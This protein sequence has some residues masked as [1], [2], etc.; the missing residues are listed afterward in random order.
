MISTNSNKKKI[1]LIIGR[2]Q[3]LTSEHLDQLLMP[4]LERCDLVIL[5][6]G[7]SNTNENI[8]SNNTLSRNEKKEWHSKNPFPFELRKRMVRD[9]IA[10]TIY[11][12]YNE[13]LIILPMPDATISHKPPSNKRVNRLL[14]EYKITPANIDSYNPANIWYYYLGKILEKYVNSNENIEIILYGSN[15]DPATEAYLLKIVKLSLKGLPFKTSF[16]EAVKNGES[17]VNATKVRAALF[18]ANRN[19]KDINYL[20]EYVPRPVLG[21]LGIEFA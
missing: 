18:K 7:S 8:N 12:T 21:I 17:T 19:Q 4:A 3:P 20:L 11:P 9:T 2:F 10:S 5:L 16:S 1:G 15:K 6:L 14:N 13:K